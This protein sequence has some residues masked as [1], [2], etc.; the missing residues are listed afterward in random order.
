MIIIICI[1]DLKQTLLD[2]IAV[3][4][5]LSRFQILEIA[6]HL[7][8]GLKEIHKANV[9]HLDVKPG[10]ILLSFDNIWKYSKPDDSWDK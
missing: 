7:V 5:W 6:L 1:A 3:N 9:I 8:V 10:N 2:K 4:S